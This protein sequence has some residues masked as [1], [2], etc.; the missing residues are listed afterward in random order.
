MADAAKPSHAPLSPTKN[1][2]AIVENPHKAK[3]EKPEKPDEQLY[4]D[5][6]AKV[7]KELT[8]AQEKLVCVTPVISEPSSELYI[9]TINSL[10]AFS[11]WADL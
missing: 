3:P 8:A 9:F 1:G 6:L 11:Q 7:E 2:A 10:L 5:S 4:K